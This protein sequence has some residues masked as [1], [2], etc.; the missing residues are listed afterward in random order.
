[1]EL[2]AGLRQNV[3]GSAPFENTPIVQV[4][5]RTEWDG[6]HRLYVSPPPRIWSVP[7]QARRFFD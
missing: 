5:F 3:P 4:T 2:L 6:T 7:V 1:L